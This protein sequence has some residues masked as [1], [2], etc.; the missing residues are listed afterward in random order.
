MTRLLRTPSAW[1]P[2]LLSLAALALIIG[3]VAR[4]GVVQQPGQDEGSAARIFQLLMLANAA[5]IGYFVLRWVPTA[6]KPAIAIVCL[7]VLLAL[8]PVVT[9]ILLES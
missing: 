8:I 3:F 5:A 2:M 4:Y 7:Q 6:P 1:V 9:I